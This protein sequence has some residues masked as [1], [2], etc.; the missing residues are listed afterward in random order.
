[1]YIL[2]ACACTT[3]LHS[4]SLM[5]TVLIQNVIFTIHLNLWFRVV[6]WDHDTNILLHIYYIYEKQFHVIQPAGWLRYV[7][8]DYTV[9]VMH[10]HTHTHTHTLNLECG[11]QYLMLPSQVTKSSKAMMAVLIG[12]TRFTRLCSLLA[13][14]FACSWSKQLAILHTHTHTHTL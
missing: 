8:H 4:I 11:H 3:P 14:L 12:K 5:E 10:A 13:C 7:Y 9:N 1:M 2:A 6:T